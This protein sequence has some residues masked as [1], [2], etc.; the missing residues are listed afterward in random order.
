L[1]HSV[2]L[3]ACSC[4]LPCWIEFH[5]DFSCIIFWFPLVQNL[6]LS[7][8]QQI[9]AKVTFLLLTKKQ[10]STKALGIKG[11]LCSLYL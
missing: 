9:V 8:G 6:P 3:L 2:P 11:E 10:E 1:T 5:F 7:Y 4:F